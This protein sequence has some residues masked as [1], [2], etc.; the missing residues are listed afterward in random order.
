[1]ER[2]RAFSELMQRLFRTFLIGCLLAGIHL[3]PAGLWL[4]ASSEARAQSKNP[5]KVVRTAGQ[6]TRLFASVDAPAGCDGFLLQ[7]PR[8]WQLEDARLLRYGSELT[9]ISTTL[10]NGQHLLEAPDVRGPHDLVLKVRPPNASQRGYSRWSVRPYAKS[11]QN[12]SVSRRPIGSVFEQGVALDAGPSNDASRSSP[13]QGE[14]NR[15]LTFKDGEGAPVQLDA[16]SVP[17]LERSVSFTVEFWFATLGLGEVVASTWSGD[18]AESYPLEI[19]VDAS[20]RIRYYHGRPGR[21]RSMSS[22][23]PVADG[24]WHHFA[25][26]YDGMERSLRLMIDGVAVDSLTGV[27][28]PGGYRRPDL[29]IGG[30]LQSPSP[31][32][33]SGPQWGLYSGQI[34][35]FRVW[36]AA[37]SPMRVRQTMR[38]GA[39]Q[40]GSSDRDDSFVVTLTFDDP[41]DESRVARWPAGAARIESTLQLWRSIHDLQA[42]MKDGRVRL[43][44]SSEAPGVAAYVVERSTDGQRFDEVQQIRPEDATPSRSSAERIFTAVDTPPAQ[45]VFY[46]LREVYT[47]GTDDVSGT[48]KVGVGPPEKKEETEIFANYPNPFSGKT[49]VEYRLHEAAQVTFTLWDVSGKRLGVVFERSLPAGRHEFSLSA[50]DLPSGT[51]FLRMQTGRASDSHQIVVLK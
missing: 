23:R 12:G 13:R 20:G 14:V 51:Y 10:L 41:S 34:D 24:R 17:A 43:T 29:A 35:V 26:S 38:D 9:P 18:E 5:E 27:S 15:V 42:S 36:N 48:F 30:R 47:D 25:V 45:V 11:V 32:M 3:G 44:W 31:R 16:R 33:K 40:R 7:L 1:M 39:I 6:S 49:T 19:M 22:Q 4:P 50:N 46:R 28:L 37:R 2:G 8:G 21:H